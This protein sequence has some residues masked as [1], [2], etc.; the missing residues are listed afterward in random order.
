MNQTKLAEARA[1][2]KTHEAE[3]LSE[4]RPMF[5][6]TPAIGWLND[7]NGFSIYRGEYHL[8]YQYHPYDIHWGP[9]YWGHVK[10]RDLI[11]WERLPAALAPDTEYDESG[12]FSG[13]ALE[14]PNGQ[15]L[16]M[17][18]GVQGGINVPEC[19]QTQCLAVGDG[20]DYQKYEKNPV[21]TADDIPEPCFAKDFRDPKIWWDEEEACFFA[22]AGILMQEESGAVALFSSKDAFHWSYVNI[23]DRCNHQYGRMWEC[24]DF[25]EMGEDHKA[26]LIVS[27]MKMQEQGLTFHNGN[28]VV[29]LIGSYDRK[30]HRFV[31][32]NVTA[33][34]YGLDFYAPQSIRTPDGRRVMIGW[35]QSWESSHLCR[36]D[37]RWHGMLTLPRELSLKDGQLIQQPVRELLGYRGDQVMHKD[38]PLAPYTRLP[39]VSGRVLDLTVDVRPES[40]GSLERFTI[41]LAENETYNTSICYNVRKGTLCLDRTDSGFHYNIVHKRRAPVRDQ[42]GKIRFRIIL[43]RFSVELFVND[44]EQVMSACLYTPQ[45]AD[46]ISFRA[47]GTGWLDVEKYELIL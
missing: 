9:M 19:R 26:V 13:S 23:L 28:D 22:V 31:R 25:F 3:V 43:D 20:I 30:E 42:G 6:I 29:C 14:L 8:F 46:G 2:E 18:T 45:E 7:P 10:S 40:E 38:V 24:P 27:A 36:R 41:C 37:G 1:Y 35:M 44:G 33:V 32:E 17:Y 4:E 5:H 39:G 16:L 12:V 34:D 15:Q 47:E 21:L 11:R